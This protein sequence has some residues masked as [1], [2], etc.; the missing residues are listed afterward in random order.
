MTL[1]KRRRTNHSVMQCVFVI[2]V[3]LVI[4]TSGQARSPETDVQLAQDAFVTNC[5]SPFMTAAKA[6]KVLNLAN[7]RYDFYDLDPFSNVAPSPVTGRA[8]TPG[9]DRRCEIA[10]DGDHR[11]PF[12]M[13]A[14]ARLQAE[15]ITTPAPVPAT[16]TATSETELLA[17]RQLN[18]KRIAVV[19]VGLRPGPNGPETFV[20]VERLEPSP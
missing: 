16:H 6:A 10:V 17:A 3:A 1:S 20:Y 5:F 2:A 14:T 8:A 11:K 7:A 4:S 19:H 18:P 12:A 15:G 13:A 9:T